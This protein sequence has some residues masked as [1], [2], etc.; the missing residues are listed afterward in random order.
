MNDQPNTP[1][2]SQ[3]S[4]D[5]E[6]VQAEAR[7]TASPTSNDRWIFTTRIAI[8]IQR[9]VPGSRVTTGHPR[10]PSERTDYRTLTPNPPLTVFGPDGRFIV[11]FLKDGTWIEATGRVSS[12]AGFLEGGPH[13]IAQLIIRE[14]GFTPPSAGWQPRGRV[15]TNHDDGLRRYLQASPTHT[16]RDVVK[17]PS[18][19]T[20]DENTPP[21]VC[22]ESVASRLILASYD[23]NSCTFTNSVHPRWGVE[24][25]RIPAIK[26]DPV[27]DRD[28]LQIEQVRAG[29]CLFTM[30]PKCP[31]SCASEDDTDQDEDLEGN[32]VWHPQRVI[33]V[34]TE[35]RDHL[36]VWLAR[37]NDVANLTA[38]PDDL[39]VFNR[40]ENH[41][42]KVLY[43]EDATWLTDYFYLDVFCDECGN[44][45]KP[46]VYGMPAS[47]DPS[48]IAVGGCVIQSDQPTYVC[49]CGNAWGSVDS[50]ER[51]DHQ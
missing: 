36:R 14:A 47:G 4:L 48:Y 6:D 11:S 23:P 9:M 30:G 25:L 29:D 8:L 19:Q 24:S 5:I 41:E 31:A 34:E 33:R 32:L 39:D 38:H 35:G 22:R 28:Y 26:V 46:I 27:T 21:S 2:Y 43:S 15:R 42:T 51:G 49:S 40:P 13:S 20:W 37:D 7:R 16:W 17:L 50:F 44:R 1:A 12:T 10:G 18:G 3:E 45:G